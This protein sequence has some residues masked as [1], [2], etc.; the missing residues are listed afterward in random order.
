MKYIIE[1]V[2]Y[3]ASKVVSNGIFILLKRITISVTIMAKLQ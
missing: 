3:R 1:F 2:D